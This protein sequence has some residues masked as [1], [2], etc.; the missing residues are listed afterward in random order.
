MPEEHNRIE[1]DRISAL[2]TPDERSK[3]VLQEE[4]VQGRIDVVGDVMAD[5]NMRLAPLARERSRILQE[6]DVQPGDYAVATVHREA[7]VQPNRLRG[8]SKACPV[9]T[10]G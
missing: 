6:V 2:F 3:D 9:W 8:S 4:G 1:V 10:S 5:A 7:N